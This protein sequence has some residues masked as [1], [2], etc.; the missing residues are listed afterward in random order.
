VTV[1]GERYRDAIEAHAKA[2]HAWDSQGGEWDALTE[3]EREWSRDVAEVGLLAATTEIA[4]P[5]RRKGVPTLG[6]TIL[7][8]PTGCQ[9]CGGSAVL[10][11]LPTTKEG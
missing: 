8:H 9:I 2:V 1:F 11:V 5:A 10:R 6:L 7:E 4:C 3:G